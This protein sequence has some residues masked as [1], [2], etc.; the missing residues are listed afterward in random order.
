MTAR[1][2]A[3][4]RRAVNVGW[5][6]LI[7]DGAL[8]APRRARDGRQPKVAR[9]YP[10][11]PANR[12]SATRVSVSILRR[13]AAELSRVITVWVPIFISAGPRLAR[14]SL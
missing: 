10:A 7:A 2:R 6:I 14:R 12:A 13:Q 5:V 1:R 8:E 9:N 11:A 3:G 4:W